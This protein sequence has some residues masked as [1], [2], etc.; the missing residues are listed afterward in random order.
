MCHAHVI[1]TTLDCKVFKEFHLISGNQR[2][3]LKVYKP[4]VLNVIIMV[5]IF[6]KCLHIKFP[7][8]TIP[9]LLAKYFII[10]ENLNRLLVSTTP[11]YFFGIVGEKT[12]SILMHTSSQR[13]Q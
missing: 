5:Y 13:S 2:S 8:R 3:G 12:N 1:I 7:I 10:N 4:R 6:T 9:R 11:L